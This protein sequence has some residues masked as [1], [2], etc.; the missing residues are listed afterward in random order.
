MLIIQD[1][2]GRSMQVLVYIQMPVRGTMGYP[3]LQLP[4]GVRELDVALHFYIYL[5]MSNRIFWNEDSCDG[6]MDTWTAIK[7]AEEDCNSWD[8][9]EYDGDG[10][11][12][13]YRGSCDI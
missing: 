3:Q 12:Y 1:S 11:S 7:I 13:A 5:I 8:C 4:H 6:D 10:S 2:S 9:M